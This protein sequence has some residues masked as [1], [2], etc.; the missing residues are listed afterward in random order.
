LAGLG[1]R[2]LGGRCSEV[3]QLIARPDL[4]RTTR[5]YIVSAYLRVQFHARGLFHFGN[6]PSRLFAAGNLVHQRVVLARIGLQAQRIK[7]AAGRNRLLDA[8]DSQDRCDVA[9]GNLPD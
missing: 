1:L 2:P 7:R 4:Q 5:K 3:P 6:D 9:D 8:G